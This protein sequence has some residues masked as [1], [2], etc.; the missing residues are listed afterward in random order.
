MH[1]THFR[2]MQHLHRAKIVA[3]FFVAFLMATNAF[4]Q[5]QNKPFYDY[6]RKLHF[7]FTVGTSISNFKY[8]WSPKWYTQDTISTVNIRRLPG[9]TLGAVGDFHMGE[10]WDI[11][12]VP[13]L[14]LSQRNLEY[15]FNNG[16]IVTKQVES[17][18]VEMPV[19]LKLK[20]ERHQNIRMYLIAGGKY[21][22]DL[23]SDYRAIKNPN[24][25]KVAIKPNN[26]SYEIGTGLDLYFPYFKF[27]PEIKLT[28]GLTN[29]L[30]PDDKPYTN[31]FSRFR[32]N[33]VFFS[34]YFEG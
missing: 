4:A 8:D 27:S 5:G 31:I 21:G 18:I 34:L 3:L 17:A 16:D 33:F 23:G 2:D 15:K 13:S 32:S 14:V 22:Y 6:G 19:L 26:Y 1:T 7:G 10:Y 20:S 11:R 28:K 9:I 12:L 24:D 25:I 30:V 29:I